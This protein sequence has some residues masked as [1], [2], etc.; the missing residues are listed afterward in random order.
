MSEASIATALVVTGAITAS[1]VVVAIVPQAALRLVFGAGRLDALTAL[2][3]RHWGL[4]VALVGGLL[5]YAAYHPDVRT[6]VMVA[7]II[8]KFA[9]ALLVFGS[10]FRKKPVAALVAGADSV[11]ALLYV[12]ILAGLS[13]HNI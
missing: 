10:S 6:P 1:V 7:A 9:I 4:L 2:V 3:A 11:M 8:E 12:A 13:T 5:I